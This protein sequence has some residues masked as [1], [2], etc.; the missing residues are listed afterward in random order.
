MVGWISDHIGRRRA[1]IGA[2][3]FAAAAVPLWAFAHALPLLVLG[4]VLMQFCVQGAWGVVPAHVAE[5]SP[6][7]VRGTLPGFANQVGLILSGLAVYLE[8]AATQGRSGGLAIS[9]PII[10][11]F[12]FVVVMAL[13]GSERRGIPFRGQEQ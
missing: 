3:I 1:M 5:L 6:D 7:P 13:A 4:V 8:A 11:A 2:M 9:M 12:C 10:V